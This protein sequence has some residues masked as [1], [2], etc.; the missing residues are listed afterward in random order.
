MNG[1]TT[2]FRVRPIRRAFRVAALCAF[3]FSS[4]EASA[5]AIFKPFSADQVHTTRK[6]TTTGKV[7]AI[8]NAMRSDAED[9]GKK[10]ISIIRFDRKV[11]WVL[12]PEQKMY[13]EM[14]WGDPAEW[15]VAA[16]G[17]QVQREPLGPEQVGAFHCDKSR[18][19]ATYQGLT[20]TYIEWAAKELDGFVLKRQDEKGSWSTEYK[21]VQL[22]AQDPSLFELP[23][24]YQK[25]SM[26]G[27]G[28]FAKP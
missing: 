25:M 13:L 12:M 2:L 23:A 14:P 9:K 8:E 3:L 1:R 19:T 10:S 4:R 11:M 16:K 15:A 27:M 20:G 24:G 28:S 18:V 17:A 7:Y 21:N 6:K 22:G 5:Q 26:G